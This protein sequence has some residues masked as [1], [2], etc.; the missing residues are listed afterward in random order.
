MQTASPGDASSA[1]SSQS[2]AVI[3]DIEGATL[4]RDLAIAPDPFTPNGD[5]INDQTAIRMNIFHLEG[6]KAIEVHIL[7]LSGR[8]RRD[9]TQASA[10]G[11]GEYKLN[12]DGRDRDGRLLPPGLYLVRVR[13]DTDQQNSNLQALRPVHLVY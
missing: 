4:L 2:L 3:S 11:S 13:V 7:D 12:W 9:L 1:S 8:P 10:N 6:A 5:G